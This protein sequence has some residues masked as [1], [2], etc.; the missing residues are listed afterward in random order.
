MTRNLP[1]FYL[2]SV[3][4]L[5]ASAPVYAQT[6]V[7]VAVPNPSAITF[8]ALYVAKGEGY[9]AD[10]GLEVDIQVVDGSPAAMQAVSARQAQVGFPGAGVFLNAVARDVDA[11]FIYNLY[12][13]SLFGLLVEDGD[14]IG[15][16]E[17]LKGGVIG[18]ASSDGA[19]VAFARSILATAGMAEGEDYQ[20]LSVGDG[21]TAAVA[22]MR[23][24]IDA[25]AGPLADAA[26][27][28]AR[29]IN[30][31]EITPPEF[32][33]F[34]GVG[35][36]A[37]RDYVDANPEI[38]E[39]FGRAIVRGSEFMTDPANLEQVFAHTAVGNPSEIENLD[40][41]QALLA[42]VV[43]RMQPLDADVDAGRGYQPLSGWE[44]W[45]QSMVD[46]G[47]LAAPIEDLEGVFTNRFVETW[48]AR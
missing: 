43:E 6:A 11:V 12:P 30:L 48:N 20:F 39:G 45:H 17:E 24:D 18:V 41:A 34:F 5:G 46:S 8:G 3:L 36:V 42:R 27:L 37:M 16:V 21:G 15:A 10:E 25:Y 22:F 44:A 38:I 1:G 23:G 7:T 35:G 14:G 32:M 31:S 47:E 28:S 33:S 2:A 13:R 9:F 4:L 19:E 26:I 40:Y 29:G